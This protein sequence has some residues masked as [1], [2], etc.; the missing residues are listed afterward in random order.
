MARIG[1][2]RSVVAVI[3]GYLVLAVLSGV[4]DFGL[5]SLVP[6]AFDADAQQYTPPWNWVFVALAFPV[7][8]LGGYIAAR[9]APGAEL[10]HALALA[11]LVLAMWVGTVL[12]TPDGVPS[13]HLM[14]LNLAGVIGVI[15][16][17]AIRSV[18]RARAE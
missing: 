4:L 2:G 11:A 3:A 12:L 1:V 9:L 17:G 18:Q 8:A 10:P 14:A 7:A 16:G 15:A 5:A 6:G 13:S